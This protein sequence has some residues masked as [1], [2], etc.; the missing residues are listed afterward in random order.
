MNVTPA[1]SWLPRHT[2]LD[3]VSE[4]RVLLWDSR[5]PR[6]HPASAVVTHEPH[7]PFFRERSGDNGGKHVIRME[8]H[9]G[10]TVRPI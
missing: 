7:V 2:D 9:F 1:L 10:I 5:A 4:L 6:V 8:W 3:V